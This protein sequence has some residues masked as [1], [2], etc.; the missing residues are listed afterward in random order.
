MG[1]NFDDVNN[2][3]GDTFRGNQ[4][5]NT[6]FYI[7]GFPGYAF[8]DGLVSGTTY[9]WRIDEVNEADPN[10]PWIGNVWSF[11]VPP[12]KAYS[13]APANSGK[14]I[15]TESTILSWIAGFGA[16]LH[17]VYFGDDFETVANATGGTSRG[18]ANF[19]PGPLELEKTD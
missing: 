12:K 3:T 15:D 13:P 16:K 18:V 11:T 6:V 4:D 14:F 10:S 1:D 19:N 8:P 7:A 17:T 2:G 9:Y 5:K